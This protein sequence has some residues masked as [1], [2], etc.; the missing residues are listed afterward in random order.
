MVAHAL[1]ADG[2]DAGEDGTGR[3]TP[4]ESRLPFTTMHKQHQLLRGPDRDTSIS[5]SVTC[6]Q[7]A[8]VAYSAM[9]MNS[10][11]DFVVRETDVASSRA[12]AAG[13]SMGDPRWRL[14][15]AGT[16]PCAGLRRGSA[17]VSQGFP[18]DYLDNITYN[19][20]PAADGP[21]YKALGNSMACNV[22]R[23][24]GR[25]IEIG[26]R[27]MNSWH[28]VDYRNEHHADQAIG[29]SRPLLSRGRRHDV[30]GIRDRDHKKRLYRQSTEAS[31]WP[32]ATRRRD[33]GCSSPSSRSRPS[34]PTPRL[35]RGCRAALSLG[36]STSMSCAP[37]R[38]PLAAGADALAL[39]PFM[40]C[41][42]PADISCP[43]CAH[44][45]R[46]A[47]GGVRVQA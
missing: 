1:R 36:T 39:P 17:R 6:S 41:G 40:Y 4:L 31:G 44:H 32:C 3:G 24:I 30:G 37:W 29:G 12:M 7:Q 43:Y 47:R 19:G 42:E 35:R 9:P 21:R 8:A 38:L 27:A 26:G 5:D 34:G 14:Y 16:G 23:W 15:P 13:P 33:R 46:M 28:A 10:G 2:F 18:D 22:M 45:T 20:K 25:R 11:K